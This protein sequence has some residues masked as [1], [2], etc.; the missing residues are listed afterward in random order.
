MA[1]PV[2]MNPTLDNAGVQDPLIYKLRRNSVYHFTDNKKITPNY[3]PFPQLSS[4][5]L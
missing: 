3:Y 1:A 2:T 5:L 4:F